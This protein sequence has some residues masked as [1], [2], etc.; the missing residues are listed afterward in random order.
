MFIV[1][2]E[3]ILFPA[4]E[5]LAAVPAG[6]EPAKA[7]EIVGLDYG[8]KLPVREN[9]QLLEQVMAALGNETQRG[10]EEV[11]ALQEGSIRIDRDSYP[12]IRN[13]KVEQKVILD[14]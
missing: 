14:T 3:V 9:M 6:V 2:G 7:V 8:R 1:I 4:S 11:L 13:P 10:G 5:K 12:V